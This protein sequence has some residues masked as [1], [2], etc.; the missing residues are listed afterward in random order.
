MI[1]VGLVLSLLL[2]FG[3]S[4]SSIEV[5]ETGTIYGHVYL[6]GTTHPIS[7]VKVSCE[8]IT[9]TTDN[10]GEY[11]LTGVP[12]GQRTITATKT[13]FEDYS[14]TINVTPG[15]NEHDIYMT[16]K[17]PCNLHGYVKHRIDGAIQGAKVTVGDFTDWTDANGHYQLPNIPQGKYAIT[18]SHPNYHDFSDSIYLY[19]MDKQFDII[20]TRTLTLTQNFT[21]DAFVASDYPDQN[22][23]DSTYLYV[24]AWYDCLTNESYYK[25]SYIQFDMPNL[26]QGA[27]IESVQ[28]YLYTSKAEDLSIKIKKVE[29][30]WYENTLTYNTQ[31]PTG[32]AW[33]REIYPCAP[34]TKIDITPLV[35]EWQSGAPNYGIMLFVS[36]GEGCCEFHSREHPS[37]PSY[38]KFYYRW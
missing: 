5:V 33:G 7:G 3:C 9:S 27:V 22:F 11:E 12:V 23:G 6:T 15:E 26:P 24:K 13:G 20:L 30:V 10:S 34:L 31:P 17:N 36:Y 2:T 38:V 4:K 18:C 25:H 1:L 35:L 19:S 37:H 16:S 21:Q 14:E 32:G 8:G 29:G 28:V